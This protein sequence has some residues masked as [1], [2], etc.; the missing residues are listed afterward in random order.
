MADV[1]VDAE[2]L[3]AERKKV[4]DRVERRRLDQ[5]DHHR[6]RQHRNAPGADE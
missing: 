4:L 6:R 1:K 2:A 3:V 5:V